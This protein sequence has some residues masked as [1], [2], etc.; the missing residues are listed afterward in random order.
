MGDLSE[1]HHES[2]YEKLSKPNG[3]WQIVQA[4]LTT[5]IL[6]MGTYM[7]NAVRD[8]NNASQEQAKS[9]VR[10]EAQMIVVQSQLVT[11]SSLPSSMVRIE[12]KLDVDEQRLKEVEQVKAKIK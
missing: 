1:I 12:T 10:L 2:R 3:I 9:L 7:I 4:I 8:A 5:V 6:L 11:L